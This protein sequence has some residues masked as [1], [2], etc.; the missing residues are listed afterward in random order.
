MREDKPTGI[1]SSA[2]GSNLEA[3]AFNISLIAPKMPL[4]AIQIMKLY[5]EASSIQI[6]DPNAPDEDQEMALEE[7][8]KF[9][10]KNT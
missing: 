2:H 9:T 5:D 7:L 1:A 3:I 10:Q 4:M 8:K 6:D